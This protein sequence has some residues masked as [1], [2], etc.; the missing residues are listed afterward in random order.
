VFHL[1]SFIRCYIFVLRRNTDFITWSVEHDED[2]LST[3]EKSRQIL[4]RKL[5]DVLSPSMSVPVCVMI[6]VSR[7]RRDLL[8]H[9]I[10]LLVFV[11]M[12]SHDFEATGEAEKENLEKKSEQR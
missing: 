1:H 10:F 9:L 8:G 6:R 4:I 3:L 5:V 11:M 7:T 12:M 2:G